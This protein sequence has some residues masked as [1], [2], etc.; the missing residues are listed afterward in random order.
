MT[1]PDQGVI[2][3][4]AT[5]VDCLFDQTMARMLLNKTIVARFK[6]LSI[7]K[8]MMTWLNPDM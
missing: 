4:L 2:M 7:R 6:Q 5:K 3:P 1:R 8:K